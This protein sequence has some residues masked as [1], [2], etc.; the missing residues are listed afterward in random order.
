MCH[1][2]SQHSTCFK[3]DF[4]RLLHSDNIPLVH[5]TI[6]TLLL[7]II[8]VMHYKLLESIVSYFSSLAFYLKTM[9]CQGM[10]IWAALMYSARISLGTDCVEE[11]NCSALCFSFLIFLKITY[12]IMQIKS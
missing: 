6:C 7:I 5:I 2:K 9:H 8:M 10:F 1:L 3:S 11:S 12:T 4:F